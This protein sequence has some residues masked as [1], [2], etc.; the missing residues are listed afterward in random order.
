MTRDQVIAVL[1]AR[2]GQRQNDLV[3]KASME[4]EILSVQTDLESNAFLPWFLQTQK[5]DLALTVAQDTIA[6]PTGYLRELDEETRK[7]A[8]YRYDATLT[9]PWVA[10][11]KYYN[12]DD[13]KERLPGAGPTLGYVT[14]GRSYIVAPVTDVSYT[15]RTRYFAKDTALET[16]IENNWLKYAEGLIRASLGEV[17]ARYYLHN[18]ALADQFKADI[19]LRRNEL[20]LAD[21]AQ[22]E[23][24]GMRQMGDD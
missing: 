18:P 11:T 24:G 13:M 19:L 17:M 7:G 14:I 12:F 2:A 1:L 8:L 4:T 15:Y 6:F 10:L 21:T 3:L 20:I 16:N 22:R 9:D 5:D 23:A